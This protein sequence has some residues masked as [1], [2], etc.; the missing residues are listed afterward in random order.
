M[1]V[2]SVKCLPTTVQPTLNAEAQNDLGFIPNPT[3]PTG[4]PSNFHDGE[5]GKIAI[6]LPQIMQDARKQTEKPTGLRRPSPSLQF[7]S[8]VCSIKESINS[9]IRCINIL[10][11][12]LVSHV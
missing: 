10:L 2:S 9:H 1:Q 6:P 5:S 11:P 4:F 12:S 7:F 8:Q 3:R